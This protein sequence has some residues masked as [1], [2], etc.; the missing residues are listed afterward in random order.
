MLGL[1]TTLVHMTV[2]TSLT[3][4]LLEDQVA[5]PARDVSSGPAVD[6][7]NSEEPS[8]P[9][10]DPSDAEDVSGADL[11][12]TLPIDNEST[13]SV[14]ELDPSDDLVRYIEFPRDG[15]EVGLELPITSLSKE[16][17]VVDPESSSGWT[18]IPPESASS[19]LTRTV[20]ADPGPQARLRRIWRWVSTLTSVLLSS[21]VVFGGMLLVI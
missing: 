17:R 4:G 8:L 15:L 9:V 6:V 21:C 19:I 3:F 11:A 13:K 16:S 1:I 10:E 12:G 14:V 7:S 18:V 20:V 5:T 2:G